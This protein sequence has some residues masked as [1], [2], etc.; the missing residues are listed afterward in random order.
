M[1]GYNIFSLS[2]NIYAFGV[3]S[4]TWYYFM[5]YMYVY[6]L[7]VC[8]YLTQS[9]LNNTKISKGRQVLKGHFRP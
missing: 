1:A 4:N 6:Q 7:Y 2:L 9:S 3:Q 5:S 8:L